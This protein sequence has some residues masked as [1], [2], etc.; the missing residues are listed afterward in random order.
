MYCND[1]FYV[2]SNYTHGNSNQAINIIGLEGEVVR[3]RNEIIAL[4]C[5]TNS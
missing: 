3:K 5:S 4:N 2:P 1:Y